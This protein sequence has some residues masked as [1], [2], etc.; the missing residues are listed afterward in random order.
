MDQTGLD[1]TQQGKGLARVGG[2]STDGDLRSEIE[3][4]HDALAV[5]EQDRLADSCHIDRM[6]IQIQILR[7]DAAAMRRRIAV[8]EGRC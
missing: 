6:A 5:M 1:T 4:L 3:R 2:V 7:G 8:L